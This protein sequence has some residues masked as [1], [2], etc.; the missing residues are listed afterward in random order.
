MGAPEP[1]ETTASPPRV[2]IGVPVYNGARFIER[3]FDTILGQTFADLE[4]VVS[5]NG[6]TDDTE[7]ICLRYAAA[8]P[9]VRYERHEVNRGA[10]WNHNRVI[11]MAH[12]EAEYFAWAA[13]DDER[14][15]TYLEKAVAVLDADPAVVVVHAGTADIDDEGYV[16]HTWRQRLAFE[17]ELPAARIK[18]L[19]T[20]NYQCFPAFGLMRLEDLRETRGLAPYA[21][22]DA[23]LIIEMALRGKIVQL[24]DVMFF[25]RQHSQRSMVA[26]AD[27]RQR[28]AWF[29]PKRKIS[30]FPKWRVG[31]EVV[32]AVHRAPL[33]RAERWRC[34]AMLRAYLRSN[35]PG[36]TKNVVRTS[37]EFT[38]AGARAANPARLAKRRPAEAPAAPPAE[39]VVGPEAAVGLEA[40]AGPTRSRRRPGSRDIPPAGRGRRR[41]G[42]TGADMTHESKR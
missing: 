26:F 40:V 1:V 32:R 41:I 22:S 33:G 4:M 17:Q 23:V 2:S 30:R 21:D 36:L 29:D 16:L 39:A 34:Y 15:P 3:T 7:Q 24:P 14:E 28:I 37:V 20:F 19:L 27:R 35:W 31:I 11:E 8:D 38:V 6:S 10:S 42:L 18:R 25:R 12:P 13:A 5:D 9:R